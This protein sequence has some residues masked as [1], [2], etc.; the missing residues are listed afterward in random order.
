MTRR[1]SSSNPALDH[2]GFNV[3][4]RA[5]I[6]LAY[7][8]SWRNVLFEFVWC[9]AVISQLIIVFSADL[10][11][12]LDGPIHLYYVDVIRGLLNHTAPY[13]SVFTLR[14]PLPPYPFQ[15]ASMLLL[16]KLFSPFAA[17]KV[18]LGLYVLWFAITTRYLARSIGP[19]WRVASVMSL[20]LTL[21]SCVYMGFFNYCLAVPTA[22]GLIG[23]WMRN[24][25]QL[26]LIK[27]AVFA[28]GFLTLATMHPVA[29][30][31]LIGYIAFHS[32]FLF[33]RTYK[34]CEP[35]S[36][37]YALR[38]CSA[39]LLPL[40]LSVPIGLWLLSVRQSVPL[41]AIPHQD[42]AVRR[43]IS[44][45][46]L[47]PVIPVTSA[48]YR[49]MLMGVFAGAWLLALIQIWR[50]HRV[51]VLIVFR[52][53]LIST[54]ALMLLLYS[55]VPPE[56]NGNG[57]FPVRFCIFA[58]LMMLSALALADFPMFAGNVLMAAVLLC[59]V[60]TL[61][62]SPLH[63]EFARQI[64]PLLVGRMAFPSTELTIVAEDCGAPP[65][66][67]PECGFSPYFHA[68]THFARNSQAIYTGLP[69]ATLSMTPVKQRGD[70]LWGGIIP[71]CKTPPAHRRVEFPFP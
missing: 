36:L 35:P 30:L 12:S 14:S 25:Q 7:T 32:A 52:G 10:F 9:A 43:L 65:T 1:S 21:H 13:S 18:L 57:Y 8:G 41:S 49:H 54:T 66:M 42:T 23:F 26:T 17:E 64:K 19:G 55:V 3:G 34:A 69:W 22:L 46:G 6:D 45:A 44:A 11:P 24:A 53:A 51:R 58:S 37:L 31:V 63:R 27:G 40:L 38:N 68:G 16:E 70:Y 61:K 2:P 62:M 20:V 67:C 33:G 48:Y 47:W 60:N 39:V 5:G 29:V 59:V 56:I 50:K 4:D 15:Y 71:S 28:L